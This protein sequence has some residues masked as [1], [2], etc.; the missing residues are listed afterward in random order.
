[1]WPKL[2]INQSP[3]CML[4]LTVKKYNLI[5]IKWNDCRFQLNFVMYCIITFWCHRVVFLSFV[6]AA[7]RVRLPSRYETQGQTMKC[8]MSNIRSCC[9]LLLHVFLPHF[10][11]FCLGVFK[12]LKS[13]TGVCSI[14][15]SFVLWFA[16]FSYFCKELFQIF[17]ML[18]LR[19]YYLE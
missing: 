15:H 13:L 7:V 9:C 4:L 5:T 16:L 6:Y 11:T 1:M 17:S 18:I 8:A 2:T 12:I 3:K 19:S 10:R 14:N